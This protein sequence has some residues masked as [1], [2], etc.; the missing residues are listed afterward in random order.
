VNGVS[1]SQT[2]PWKATGRSR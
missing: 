2:T 1:Y